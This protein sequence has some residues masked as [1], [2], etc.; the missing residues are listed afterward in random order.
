MS[1]HT[2]WMIDLVLAYED[3]SD[4]K[5]IKHILNTTLAD[6]SISLSEIYQVLKKRAYGIELNNK[7]NL[8]SLFRDDPKKIITI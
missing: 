3:T 1:Y 4:P 2:E 6:D 8:A 7:L 5:R